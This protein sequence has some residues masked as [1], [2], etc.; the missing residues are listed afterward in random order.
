MAPHYNITTP[1]P[2]VIGKVRS[3]KKKLFA[4]SKITNKWLGEEGTNGCRLFYFIFK[5]VLFFVYRTEQNTKDII[6]L[7]K[8]RRSI[9]K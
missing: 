4:L 7:I 3:H 8:T 2:H 1:T 5:K 6:L 9:L